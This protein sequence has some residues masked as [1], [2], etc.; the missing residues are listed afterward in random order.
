M[1]SIC[2]AAIKIS[3]G[4]LPVVI[5][6]QDILVDLCLPWSNNKIFNVRLPFEEM[7][8]FFMHRLSFGGSVDLEEDERRRV[9]IGLK[10][11]KSD[12][13]VFSRML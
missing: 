5:S 11:V 9:I 4:W 3:E 1:P 6:G 10:N 2:I 13:S 8:R 7:R 12:N